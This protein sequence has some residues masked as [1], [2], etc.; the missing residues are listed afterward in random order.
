[1]LTHR[2]DIATI[3]LNTHSHPESLL[4]PYIV[5]LC[6]RR[7]LI[8]PTYQFSHT[9]GYC[10]QLFLCPLL[11]PAVTGQNC[12]HAQFPKVKSCV[13]DLNWERGAQMRVTLDRR[14]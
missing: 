11:F 3:P 10:S 7:Y 1:M 14:Y 6:E 2:H 5:P 9:Y 4:A 13:K 12:D 8:H